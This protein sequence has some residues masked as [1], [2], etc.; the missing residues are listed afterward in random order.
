MQ[1]GAVKKILVF[2]ALAYLFLGLFSFGTHAALPDMLEIHGQ[3][4]AQPSMGHGDCSGNTCVESAAATTTCLKHC[5]QEAANTTQFTTPAPTVVVFYLL[6]AVVLAVIAIWQSSDTLRPRAVLWPQ[7]L[8][9][10]N[11]SQLRE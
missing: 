3:A 4:V 11:T 9:L 8:Y 6:V 7:P 5:I 2:S 10:F 1:L